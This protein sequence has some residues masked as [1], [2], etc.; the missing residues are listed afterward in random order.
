[1]G[2]KEP[3]HARAIVVQDEK[4]LVIWR[5]RK[6]QHYFVLPGGHIEEGEPPEY[7]VSREVAEET[8]LKVQLLRQLYRH[9]R[10]GS[11]DTTYFYLCQYISGQP[12]LPLDSEEAL[13]SNKDNSYKP[14]W[15]TY[16]EVADYWCYPTTVTKQILQDWH[17]NCW[18]AKT[19]DIID[20]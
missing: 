18:P 16:Q 1:M 7:T 10:V 13:R 17:N 12:S 19:T 9:R 14:A 20:S 4:I 2:F 15:A 11:V 8:S 5:F 6:G 3:T